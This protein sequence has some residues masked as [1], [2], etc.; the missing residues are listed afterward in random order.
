MKKLLYQKVFDDLEKK[1]IDGVYIINNKLPSEQELAEQYKV[2]VITIKRA[3]GE[4]KEKGYVS[5]KPK[6]GTIVISN[7]KVIKNIPS[8]K[9]SL[10]LIGCILTNFDDTF[11]TQILSGILE[12]SDSNAHVIV[13]K[14]LG[15]EEKEE[16][17]IQEF[18]NMDVAGIIL[19]PSSSKY[20][21][22]TI[23]EL[24]SQKFPFIIIDRTL[25]G[26]PISSITTNNKESAEKLTSYLISLGHKNI[27]LITSTNLVSTVEERIQGYTQA[28]AVHQIKMNYSLRKHFV[29]SVTPASD[30]TVEEDIQKIATFIK[31][32]PNMT[33]IVATEYNIALLTKQACEIVGKKVPNDISIVCFDHPDNYFDRTSFYFTHIDQKQYK[34]GSYCIQQLLQQIQS[35]TSVV[36][37]TLSGKLIIGNSTKELQ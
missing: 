11:G 6:Q 29:G 32:H 15:H 5:R 17:L 33:G 23:L 35:P 19:L 20:L 14:S 21:S 25:E 10:P 16:E 2:S 4:L 1:I 22:P 34:L 18:I 8:Q 31:E 26:L 7:T 13:K 36:K 28:H 12:E 24:A 37:E 9:F 30:V 3:L 27:G